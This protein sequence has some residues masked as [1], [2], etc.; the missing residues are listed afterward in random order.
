[1]V[2]VVSLQSV[3][4]L[5]GLLAVLNVVLL[6]LVLGHRRRIVATET[7]IEEHVETVAGTL[8][9]GL[10]D[11]V[12]G[13]QDTVM[14][15]SDD[16]EDIQADVATLGDRLPEVERTLARLDG[17]LDGF[18][19]GGLA[20][21]AD[22]VEAVQSGLEGIESDISSVD[23]TVGQAGESLD[24]LED[25]M[26]ALE[27]EVAHVR[28]LAGSL[29]N[30][31]GIP[32]ELAEIEGRLTRIEAVLTDLGR[33]GQDRS[34]AG[35]TPGEESMDDWISGSEAEPGTDE[36]PDDGTT[37]DTAAEDELW[38]DPSDPID[39]DSGS[40]ADTDGD[41]STGSDDAGESGAFDLAETDDDPEEL[42][43]GDGDPR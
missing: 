14:P 3:V 38:A 39:A 5:L 42:D 18:S 25:A 7:A 29:S 43:E 33:T 4:A 2:S 27:R 12:V 20:R 1:M 17:R 40:R 30:E 36:D 6:A 16:I 32:A 23:T 11:E 24:G 10:A 37:V 9:A 41:G 34:I 35:A 15:L 31:T 22:R 21:I 19:E 28:E 26:E 13:I 8:E